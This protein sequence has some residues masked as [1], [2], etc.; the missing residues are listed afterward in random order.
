MEKSLSDILLE[1][2]E[3][4]TP[5]LDIVEEMDITKEPERFIPK[6][7]DKFSDKL[8]AY[9]GEHKVGDKTISISPVR[10]VYNNLVGVKFEFK[11]SF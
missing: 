5:V 6:D 11:M 4:F 9:L 10:D 1:N 7:S 8:F 2:S 3:D